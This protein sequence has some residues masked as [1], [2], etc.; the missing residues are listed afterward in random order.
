MSEGPPPPAPANEPP[1]QE[2]LGPQIAEMTK[3]LS[4][5]LLDEMG[6][7]VSKASGPAVVS[8]E[9]VIPEGGG[10]VIETTKFAVV[11]GQEDGIDPIINYQFESVYEHDN[12]GQSVRERRESLLSRIDTGAQTAIY[13]VEGAGNAPDPQQDTQLHAKLSDLQQPGNSATITF[14]QPRPESS[15][16]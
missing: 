3:K 12:G 2:G 6:L 15:I 16:L 10:S 7:P 4:T 1:D 8:Y 13:W 11:P 5:G 9:R 14:H